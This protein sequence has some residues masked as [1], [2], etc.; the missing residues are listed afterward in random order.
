VKF[1]KPC[2]GVEM[3]DT[4]CVGSLENVEVPT[5]YL[6]PDSCGT[7]WCDGY[8]W[9][10]PGTS[11]RFPNDDGRHEPLSQFPVEWWYANFHL[12][13]QTTGKE[14]GAF[15][16]FFKDGPMRLFAI[17]DL[18][19][20]QYYSGAKLSAIMTASSDE[21]DI[22]YEDQILDNDLW[23]NA[24][25]CGGAP[26][27]P[28]LQRLNV[29]ATADQ[30]GQKIAL[31]VYMQATK[32]PMLVGGDGRIPIGE[33]S[34]YYYSFPRMKVT[35]VIEAH[36][37][38]EYVEGEAWFDHQWGDFMGITKKVNWRWFALQLDDG[39]EIMTGDVW[40]DGVA[41]GSGSFTGGMNLY[42]QDCSL[43]LLQDTVIVLEWWL[44]PES[45][46]TFETKWHI[47]QNSRDI[48]LVVTADF[49]D[50][51]MRS[52][53]SSVFPGAVFW[54]GACSV[55][56]TIGGESVSGR[57][58]VEQTRPGAKTEIGGS[59]ICFKVVTD[60]THYWPS[61]SDTRLR[62]M[63]DHYLPTS[64]IDGALI[65]FT[66]C[67]GGDMME[68]F[69][70]RPNTVVLSATSPDQ[71]S[72]YGGYDDDA[73][74]FLR[75]G[76]GWNS[77]SLHSRASAGAFPFEAPCKQG[78][79]FSLEPTSPTGPIKGRHII[80]Y[81]GVPDSD[82]LHQF[83]DVGYI[84]T[85]RDN[86]EGAYRT[87]FYTVCAKGPVDGF[88]YWAS[89]SG[90]ERALRDI[91]DSVMATPNEQVILFVSDHGYR[92]LVLDYDP[93]CTM[94]DCPSTGNA[95]FADSTWQQMLDD[96]NNT[97]D[98][99]VVSDSCYIEPLSVSYCGKTYDSVFFNC[100]DTI[101]YSQGDEAINAWGAAVQIDESDVWPEGDFLQ[102]S[103]PPGLHILEVSL[104]T[105]AIAKVKGYHFDCIPGDANGS[106]GDPAVDIDDIVYLINYVFG[107]GP[108][109]VGDLCCGDANGS[110]GDPPVDIDDIVYLINYVFGGGPAP[111]HVCPF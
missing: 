93:V 62:L 71:T 98:I 53:L 102:I 92:R 13:G 54:E 1:F 8:P 46:S 67:Y 35:G 109:P 26:L 40:V 42:N 56:G 77:D 10:P 5:K 68:N 100:S 4:I 111:V 2:F 66:Q 76:E 74:E 94:G 99:T 7:G 61:I 73:A 60:T 52:L 30:D 90:L 48:D 85:I 21:L 18:V 19:S 44:D 47:L 3:E 83:S 39:R 79:V 43:D 91:Q 69:I 50:Q 95:A 97:P 25:Q 87:H 96:P 64:I 22:V 33:D 80:F 27:N 51:V 37:I 55:E 36:G 6:D 82:S 104:G 84:N 28:F 45:N 15:V 29:D 89:G 31:D 63:F 86:F 59:L 110:Q 32:A 107:G 106:G 105:G 72:E 88:D 49:P 78:G 17:S 57:A 75:P 38:K 103:G 12:I 24:Y 81:A 14:Y 108:S 41:K 11:I 65:V 16:A 58:Y 70:D 23:W 9:Y 20:K 101:E 34:T